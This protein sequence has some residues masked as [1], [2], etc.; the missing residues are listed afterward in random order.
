VIERS[1]TRNGCGAC[2]CLK[3][4]IVRSKQ[5][6]DALI[7]AVSSLRGTRMRLTRRGVYQCHRFRSIWMRSVVQG[8]PIVYV[9]RARLATFSE[10]I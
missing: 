10:I 6:N 4:R 7:V 3:F 8:N 1:G 2:L 5:P 9:L